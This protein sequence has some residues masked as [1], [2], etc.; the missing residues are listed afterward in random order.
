MTPA[1]P[2]ICPAMRQEVIANY[3][4]DMLELS[5]PISRDLPYWLE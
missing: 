2:S 5:D 1:S 3:R 4:D